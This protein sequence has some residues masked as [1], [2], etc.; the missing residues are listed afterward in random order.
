MNNK[1]TIEKLLTAD[2]RKEIAEKLL[3]EQVEEAI[4][5][6]HE[7]GKLKWL[8]TMRCTE[9]LGISEILYQ[10]AWDMLKERDE[11]DKS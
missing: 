2:D 1:L 3:D 9:L 7:N 4:I 6:Y 11:E 8:S 10:D 5:I